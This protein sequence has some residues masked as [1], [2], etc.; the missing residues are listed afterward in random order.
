MNDKMG[1]S[2][3]EFIEMSPNSRNLAAKCKFKAGEVIL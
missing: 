3:F 2:R 1:Q